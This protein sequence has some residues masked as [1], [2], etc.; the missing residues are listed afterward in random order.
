MDVKLTGIMNTGAVPPGETPV[1]GKLLAPGLYAPNH[2]HFFCFRLDPMID[3]ENNSVVEE[4]TISVDA[5]TVFGNA[6]KVQST[7]FKTEQEAQRQSDPHSGRTWKIINPEVRNPQNGAP[8]GYE[9]MAHNHIL[10][11]ASA[12]SSFLQRAAFASRHL[13]VTPYHPEERYPV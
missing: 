5:E 2:Q 3:G 4:Q 9:L 7:V 12:T 1:Y 11:F 8:V 10:P 13:W 6:F